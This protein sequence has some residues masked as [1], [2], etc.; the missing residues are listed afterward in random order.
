ML[1]FSIYLSLL[2][3]GLAVLLHSNMYTALMTLHFIATIS[4]LIAAIST[5]Y[6]IR[7]RHQVP[8]NIL[9]VSIETTVSNINWVIKYT[10]ENNST[11]YSKFLQFVWKFS[12]HKY[13]MQM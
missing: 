6:V 12:S 11:L 8:K 4:N 9:M 10:I 3:Y 5:S 7:L 1:A 13:L 2:E